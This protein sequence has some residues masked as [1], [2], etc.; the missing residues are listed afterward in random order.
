MHEAIL[1][2]ITFLKLELRA[3]FFNKEVVVVLE[4]LGD[5]SENLGDE[6]NFGSLRH[7]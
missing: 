3:F 6:S 1:E 7:L 5:N 2:N 4:N